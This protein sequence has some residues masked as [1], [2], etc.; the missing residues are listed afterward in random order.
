VDRMTIAET[1]EVLRIS[2]WTL[3]RLIKAGKVT[4][5]KRSPNVRNSPVD[6]DAASVRDYIDRHTVPATAKTRTGA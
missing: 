5:A 3:D 2:R 4:A 1:C 6:I